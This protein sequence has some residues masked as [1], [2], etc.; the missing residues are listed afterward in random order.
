VS[1]AIPTI[2]PYIRT[3]PDGVPL[4]SREFAEW[5]KSSLARAGM[6]VAAKALAM[7]ALDLIADPQALRRAKDEFART[8][9]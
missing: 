5:A 8:P 4:H 2:H 3:A 7:T 9:P 1:Q 6:V